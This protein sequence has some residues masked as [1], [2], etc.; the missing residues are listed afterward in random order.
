MVVAPD[1]PAAP[2]TMYHGMIHHWMIK[3]FR[4]A[5][6]QLILV[7]RRVP[8]GF[9]PDIAKVA[10][11]KLVQVNNAVQLGDLAVPPGN[12]LEALQGDLAGKYSVR[13][14]DRWRIIFRCTEAGPEEVEISDHYK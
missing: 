4:G 1:C 14:N 12:S 13:I 8:K 9:P 5:F 2:C 11:R 10:R 7:D 3:S 6:A